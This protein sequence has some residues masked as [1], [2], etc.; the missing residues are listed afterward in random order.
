LDRL[1]GD[2]ITA[3]EEETEAGEV[4]A[5]IWYNGDCR[6]LRL[7]LKVMVPLVI[8]SLLFRFRGDDRVA[9]P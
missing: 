4:T 1:D 5:A 6:A 2:A 9:T 8:L 7:G 3:E